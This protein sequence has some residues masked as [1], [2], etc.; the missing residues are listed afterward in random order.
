MVLKPMGVMRLNKKNPILITAIT[1]LGLLV[2]AGIIITILAIVQHWNVLAWIGSKQFWLIVFIVAFV[3][4]SAASY[5]IYYLIIG[6][7]K[8]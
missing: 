2:I 6:K 5:I 1:G 8:K 3:G 7:Y 4:I